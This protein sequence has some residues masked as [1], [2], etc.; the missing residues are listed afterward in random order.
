VNSDVSVHILP[1]PYQQQEL[2]AEIGKAIAEHKER[3][4]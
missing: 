1:K 3:Q 4:S 2:S